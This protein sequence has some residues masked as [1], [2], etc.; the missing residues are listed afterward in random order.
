[1]NLFE[2]TLKTRTGQLRDMLLSA[3]VIAIG[4]TEYILSLARDITNRKRTERALKESE[5]RYRKITAA[6]TDY[7]YTV[8]LEEGN[9]TRTVHSPA[10]EAVTGYS[11]EDFEKDPYLWFSMVVEEDRGMVREHFNRVTAGERVIPIEH[12]IRRKDGSVRWVSNMPVIHR[13]R[14]APWIPMTEW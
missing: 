6:I 14:P 2:A 4:G 10:C 13:T 7:I 8:Y 3:S 1:V 11:A 5:E 9:V 12:R